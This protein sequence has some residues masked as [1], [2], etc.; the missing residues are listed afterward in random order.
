MISGRRKPPTHHKKIEH[1]LRQ[2]VEAGVF[3]NDLKSGG[4]VDL[5][6]RFGD[7][8]G[9]DTIEPWLSPKR[10]TQINRIE[11]SRQALVTSATLSGAGIP[12]VVVGWVK[13]AR[14]KVCP[15]NKH[16]TGKILSRLY[17]L[18]ECRPTND[19]KWQSVWA[20]L[21]PQW[22][23]GANDETHVNRYFQPPGFQVQE[24]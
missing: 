2:S 13:F 8:H 16:G 4:L 21:A 20:R 9:F 12:V 19:L 5:L 3:C 7:S 14:F 23:V 17:S 15:T 10:L 22:W 1:P 18:S 6:S 24:R 11:L